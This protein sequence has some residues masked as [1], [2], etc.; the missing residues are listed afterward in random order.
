M[1]E[2]HSSDFVESPL[3]GYYA[4]SAEVLVPYKTMNFLRVVAAKAVEA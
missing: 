4:L 2:L 1:C 3:V